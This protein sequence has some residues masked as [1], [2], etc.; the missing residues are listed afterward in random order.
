MT[1]LL[2]VVLIE[3]TIG[4]AI[5]KLKWKKAPDIKLKLG[6]KYSFYYL[7]VAPSFSILSAISTF[8]L[9]NPNIGNFDKIL[10]FQLLIVYIIVDGLVFILSLGK[11]HL[12]DY[13]LNLNINQ[14]NFVKKPF[15]TLGVVY[16]FFGLLFFASIYTYKYNLTFSSLS[17]S[18]NNSI[19]KEQYPTDLF[20]GSYVF[21]LKEK[22]P[23][24]FTPSKP[25]SFIYTQK[26]PQKTLYLNLPE[27][28]FN[29]ETERKKVCIDLIL[30]SNRNDVFSD[31][32]PRQTRIVLS[33]IKRGFFLEYYNYFYIY[34]FD[35]KLPDW[36]IYGGVKADSIT[37]KNYINFNYNF[38]K[39][40][41]A[42]INL[43]E[44]EFGLTW[45]EIVEKAE[46]NKEFEEKV[47][48]LYNTYFETTFYG[49]RL[50]IKIDSSK[51]VLN[52][53]NF[54]DTKLNGCMGINFPV[55]NL[56]QRVNLTNHLNGEI[57]EYDENV[58]YLKL[59]REEVTNEGI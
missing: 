30:K 9:L 49:N 35:N 6:L 22:S 28:V 37:M 19:Y 16:L 40:L 53:I 23:N 7:S 50:E 59:L 46:T 48:K 45:N 51:L 17:D 57:I 56:E 18:F 25:L 32:E 42:K 10:S 38:N 55:S 39:G 26:L 31:F 41:L 1:F 33:N 54:S 44:K 43:I 8:P 52:R 29:S 2:P 13:V 15:K 5:V 47:Q 12:A 11:F 21:T 27:D 58:D 3:N 34:Y 24:V 14:H 36:N 4:K 20:Y